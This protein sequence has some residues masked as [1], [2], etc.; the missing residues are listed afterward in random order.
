M[1]VETA[2]CKKCGS[3]CE[4]GGP[5]LHI[6]DLELIRSGT[7]P[8]S[9]LITIRKGELVHNPITGQVQPASV[10]L[11]KLVGTGKSWN[12]CY[13][14]E[15]SGCTIYVNRPHTCRL[16]KCWDSDE[17]LSVI[18]KDTLDRF[19]ILAEDD[20]LIPIIVEHE[21]VC[22]CAILQEIKLNRENLTKAQK[23]EI[24][25]QVRQDLRFRQRI[26]KDFNLK[27]SEELFY[28]GRPFFQLLQPLGIRIFESNQEI[29]LKW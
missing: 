24:E 5:A 2:S 12:C 21:R 23:G 14:D 6:Q 13:Y 8:V 4:K 29:H 22:P 7:I 25:K 10:E 3:C 19:M 16:L 17:L 18:E 11:V 20:P 1:I 27:L 26:I 28:F 9:S 15:D